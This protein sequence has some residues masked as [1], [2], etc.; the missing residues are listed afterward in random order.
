MRRTLLLTAA[1]MLV[2]GFAFAQAGS[3][4]LYSDTVGVGSCDIDDS[5]PAF[6]TIYVMHENCPGTT[7]SRFKIDQIDGGTLVYVTEATTMPLKIGNAQD[8]VA[9]SYGTC[10]TSPLLILTVYY[11]GA[12][13]SAVCSRLKVVADPVADPPV[14]QSANCQDPPQILEG[15]GGEAIINADGV[16]C[17]YCDPPVQPTSWGRIKALYR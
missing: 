17:N 9:L 7:A 12:G 4:A 6:Q 10:L 15:I 2:A 1:L 14:V 16:T 3:I 8:G 5:S 13:T 11:N